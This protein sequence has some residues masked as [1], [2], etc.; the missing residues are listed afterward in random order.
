MHQHKFW[1]VINGKTT[2]FWTALAGSTTPRESQ[3]KKKIT[4]HKALDQNKWVDPALN[5]FTIHAISIR[6]SSNGVKLRV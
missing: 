5:F 2:L 3:K 1:L 6:F 4:V